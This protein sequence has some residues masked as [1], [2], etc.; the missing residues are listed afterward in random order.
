MQPFFTYFDIPNL[1][2]P[3]LSPIMGGMQQCDRN[4][5]YGPVMRRYYIIE[6]IISGCG[7]YTVNGH[8]HKGKA[9][10][11]FIIKP[12]EVH[13][14]RADN[15]DPWQYV[16]VGFSTELELPEIMHN[17]YVFDATEVSD[18]FMRLADGNHQDRKATDYATALFCLFS[19]YYALQKNAQKEPLNSIDKAIAIIKN[20]YATITVQK[21]ADRLFL[22][23][24]YFGA[25]FKKKTGKSPKEYIDE[26]R[27][28]AAAMMMTELGYTATQ[29]ALATGYSD[30][31]CFSRMYKKHFGKPPRKSIEKRSP[32]GGSIILK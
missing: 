28:S 24:S 17:N 31:M 13:L 11:A 12:F 19:R 20:E 7:E 22:N 10:E 30:V 4:Y 25:N 23:R 32:K 6:Y 18:I 26:T 5:T 2:L 3:Y 29:A 8:V 15:N 21:L 16:W 9:G 27:M 1:G 14:L